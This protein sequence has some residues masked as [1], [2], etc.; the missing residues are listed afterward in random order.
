MAVFGCLSLTDSFLSVRLSRT[1]S[2]SFV[3]RLA[4]LGDEKFEILLC[5]RIW[6]HPSG[7]ENVKAE[8]IQMTGRFEI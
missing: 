4:I 7:F 1:V 8:I 2:V 6:D 5:N 3:S